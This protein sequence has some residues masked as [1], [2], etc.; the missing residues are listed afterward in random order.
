[1]DSERIQ[2]IAEAIANRVYGPSISSTKRRNT[3]IYKEI[4]TQHVEEWISSKE[5][6][7]QKA[8]KDIEEVIRAV[9]ILPCTCYDSYTLSKDCPKHFHLDLYEPD[10]KRAEQAIVTLKKGR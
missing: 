5:K 7:Y 2:F 3:E 9:K 4:I 6:D 1:M 8:I 10:I